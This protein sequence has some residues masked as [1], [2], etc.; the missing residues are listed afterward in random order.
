[1]VVIPPSRSGRQ[2][3]DIAIEAT[4]AAGEIVMDHFSREKHVHVK[5]QGN[6]VTDADL[7]S[8][9]L[10]LERLRSEFPDF[11]ITSEESDRVPSQNGYTWLVDP[12]DGT[13]NYSFGIPFFT[14][15]IALAQ[16]DRM[17]L[18][19]TFDP[20]RHELFHAIAGEGAFLNGQRI[21]V[22]PR[23]DPKTALIGFDIGYEMGKGQETLEIAGALR[24]SVF[25][26]RVLGSGAM[27]LAYVACGR[28]DIYMHRRLYPWDIAA[29]RLLI[30]EAGGMATDWQG[31]PL[32]QEGREIV[33]GNKAIHRF[34]MET[35]R[36]S[37]PPAA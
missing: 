2:A 22:S 35:V 1:M 36:K 21:S 11:G 17:L 7:L 6:L 9:K 28:L 14:V 8:E 32:A 31:K 15:N 25:S 37:R 26:Y 16:G 27:A 19:L 24:P 30:E 10:I 13:N 23:T 29:G 34:V 33:A 12:L 5:G 20:L 4:K 18:G 3:L